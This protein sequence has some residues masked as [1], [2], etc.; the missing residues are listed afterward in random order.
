M[1][2]R[3]TIGRARYVPGGVDADGYSRAAGF[4]DPE[5]VSVYGWQPLASDMPVGAELTRR[6]ITSKLVLVPDVSLWQPTDK[7]WLYGLAI[8]GE[9][10]PADPKDFY[11]VSEDVRDFNTG[12]FGYKPG[13]A[14][15]IER[16]QG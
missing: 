10:T 7:V 6:I 14:V 3:F 2:A 9:F 13:G 1:R 4:A 12:P 16:T 8:D 11:Q 5:P 15:V